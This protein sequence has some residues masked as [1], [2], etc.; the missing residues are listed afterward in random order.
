MLVAIQWC[1]GTSAGALHRSTAPSLW[2]GCEAHPPIAPRCACARALA[3]STCS[4]R[5]CL[6]RAPTI[7]PLNSPRPTLSDGEGPTPLVPP[8]VAPA[9]ILSS[10]A[11][12]ALEWCAEI[13]DAMA[14]PATA[15]E[16]V[17]SFTPM[18][19]MLPPLATRA[20]ERWL[21][22][23]AFDLLRNVGSLLPEE[24]RKAARGVSSG[25]WDLFAP[26]P[27]NGPLVRR[28]TT[29]TLLLFPR[30]ARKDCWCPPAPLAFVVGEAPDMF[31]RGTTGPSAQETWATLALE[32]A[33]VPLPKLTLPQG[34]LL[35]DEEDGGDGVEDA[36]TL[37]DALGDVDEQDDGDRV[38][39]SLPN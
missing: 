12:A 17:T 36:S 13:D 5:C 22:V 11:E 16:A 2:K 38:V 4:L 14:C 37:A 32:E 23:R 29:S 25:A 7:N 33:V 6:L 3:A 15:S 34:E 8:L 35:C 31:L 28:E 27:A 19:P 10:L 20:R 26:P 24:V 21:D 39:E 9:W 30:W 1:H 18:V